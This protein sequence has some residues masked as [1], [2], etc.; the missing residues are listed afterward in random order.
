MS[1]R[2][3]LWQGAS[4][5]FWLSF[6]AWTAL[7][8]LHFTFN[9]SFGQHPRFSQF[10]GFC[11]VLVLLC[12]LFCAVANFLWTGY[13]PFYFMFPKSRERVARRKL[14]IEQELEGSEDIVTS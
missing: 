6:I 7:N 12:S 10:Y 5:A 1:R 8:L 13:Y 2:R 14:E 3:K 9:I 4:R 11:C